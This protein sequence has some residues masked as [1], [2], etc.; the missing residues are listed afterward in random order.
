MS[1]RDSLETVRPL[2]PQDAKASFK[3][4]DW[5][6]SASFGEAFQR[7][8]FLLKKEFRWL[9]L[10]FFIGGLTLSI[11][12]MPV[13]SI[14]ST[15]DIL[16][17]NE[18]FAPIPDVIVLIDLLIKSVLWGLVRN[19]VIFFGT[20]ILGT[21]VIYH[22]IKAV[23]SLYLLAP[24]YSSIRFPLL[25]TLGAASITATILSLSSI[26]PLIGSVIQVLFFFL[27]TLLVLGHLSLVQSFTLSSHMQVQHWGRILSALFLGYILILFAGTIGVTVYLD[28][29]VV[30]TLYGIS[31]GLAGPILLSILT[32][33][34]VAMVAPLV[35]LF[36]V[37][38]FG[39]ARG[40]YR[41]KQHQKFMRQQQQ[42]H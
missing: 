20:F 42:Y 35:P 2:A 33:I 9:V 18:V 3:G 1:E 4:K 23:P 19:F 37:A 28:I 38:F 32:Q 11:S 17:V 30:L 16:I 5:L 21:F 7:T 41:E 6:A 25:S 34:P 15:I 26:L 24:N 10:V 27:P 40:A 22:V 39:G 13:N 12:L 31:L 8:I 36:S 29:E 14:V